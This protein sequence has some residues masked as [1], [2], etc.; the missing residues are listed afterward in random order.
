M[1]NM[2]ENILEILRK[3]ISEILEEQERLEQ[4]VDNKLEPLSKLKEKLN[5]VIS[6]S[7]NF[8]LLE[9]DVKEAKFLATARSYPA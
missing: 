8:K 5:M 9:E 2:I 6:D 7:E 1:I 4:E 3:E